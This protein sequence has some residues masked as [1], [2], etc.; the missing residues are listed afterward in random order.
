[1]VIRQEGVLEDA[2]AD[3]PHH[4]VI[5]EDV[6]LAEERPAERLLGLGEVMQIAAR[7]LGADRALAQGVDLLLRELI[8]RAAQLQDATRGIRRSEL[9]DFVRDDAVE[10][11]D[12]AVDGFEEVERGADAHQVARLVVREHRRG[13]LTRVFALGLA[14]ADREAA[15]GEPVEGQLGQA[16]GA[17]LAEVGVEGA[18]DDRE[19]RLG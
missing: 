4:L 15:D 2:L 14:F 18:L 5:E 6:V 11:V 3:L 9:G 10:H 16:V 1:M 7:I 8:D 13:D 12:A 19:H 17:D